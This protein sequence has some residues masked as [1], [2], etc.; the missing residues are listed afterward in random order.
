MINV[1]MIGFGGI[2][3]AHRAAY[4][5]L[6]AQGLQV[7]LAAVC[8]I[9]PMRFEK[10]TV[11]NID[12]GSDDLNFTF[13][14]YLSVDE[15]LENEKLDIIDICLPT[16]LHASTAVAMLEK[17]YHVLSEKP[18]AYN[19]EDCKRMLDAAE[20]SGKLLM[21]G[22]CLRFYNEYDF[23]KQCVLDGRFGKPQ[24]AYFS[25]LSGP[26]IWGWKNW[27]MNYSMSGGCLTDMHI[28]DIDMAR[29]LFGEP[30]AVVCRTKDSAS[31]S[32]DVTTVLYYDDISVTAIGQWSLVGYPFAMSYRIR[33]EKATVAFENGKVTVYPADGSESYSPDITAR[34]GIEGEIEYFVGL[35][36]NGASNEKNPPIS[37]AKSLK[38]IEALRL[39][40][41]KG[42]EKIEF[43]ADI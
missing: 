20:K 30:N 34:D 40:A 36:E 27:F 26:P 9:D 28:H 11:I 2:A 17:G 14:R 39:S 5:K 42:G 16:P 13:N 15:M 7:N 25:R 32:D 1:G 3:Q 43:S 23:V 8:D 22:Q 31:K 19:S 24:T 38:L 29:H 4:Q 21:I 10:R 6:I 37:A 18:M 12:T 33:F 35:I 41:E